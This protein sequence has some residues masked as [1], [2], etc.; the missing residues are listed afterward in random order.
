MA[1][2]LTEVLPIKPGQGTGRDN[3][4]LRDR[5]L[6]TFQMHATGVHFGSWTTHVGETEAS[7]K[8]NAA[9]NIWTVP[10]GV[11][12]AKFEIWGA[13]G[14]GAGASC[15]QQGI[16]GGSGA[17]A[18]KEISVTPGDRYVLCLG[19]YSEFCCTNRCYGSAMSQGCLAKQTGYKVP[20][21]SV[22]GNNL[23]N[24]CAEGG[25]PGVTAFCPAYHMHGREPGA[26][27]VGERACCCYCWT[28][29]DMYLG[30]PTGQYRTLDSDN[31]IM[32]CACYYG[33]DGGVRG[34]RGYL[35]TSCCNVNANAN[36][37]GIKYGIPYPGGLWEKSD[38][39]YRG[40]VIEVAANFCCHC[41]AP[42]GQQ[43][44]IAASSLNHFPQD[45]GHETSLRGLGGASAQVSDG[46]SCCGSR[47]GPSAVWISYC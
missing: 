31:D 26:G 14:G 37:C 17:Y 33:A 38:R 1:K 15:C 23:S 21:V 7:A 29:C 5:Y 44:C 40:G 25:N 11:S 8:L 9:R 46:P 32:R 42:S 3:F 36:A 30:G 47:G 18:Y 4:R 22:K 2:I 39:G 20:T 19:D 41:C 24:F 43:Q 35:K 13:G 28:V 45:G 6:Y 34:A 27:G 16:S 10:T 12:L